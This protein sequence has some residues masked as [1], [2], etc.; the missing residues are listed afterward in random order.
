MI[1]W[2]YEDK[3]VVVDSD[4][5]QNSA[6]RYVKMYTENSNGIHCGNSRY[7]K[8]YCT[9]YILLMPYLGTHLQKMGSHYRT[10]NKPAT[11]S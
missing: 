5:S 3:S 2:Q 8:Q 1:I 6:R 4:A 9:I 10:T 11:D 7:K